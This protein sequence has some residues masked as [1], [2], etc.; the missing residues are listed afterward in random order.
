MSV[1]SWHVLFGP[2]CLE[3]EKVYLLSTM[4]NEKILQR[5]SD[6]QLLNFF[7]KKLAGVT[8]LGWS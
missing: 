2:K 4:K 7:G 5:S 1:A 8:A 3:N 6:F